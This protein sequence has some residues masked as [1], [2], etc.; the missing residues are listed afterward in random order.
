MSLGVGG[1]VFVTWLLICIYLRRTDFPPVSCHLHHVHDINVVVAIE[2]VAFIIT[3][4]SKL[5]APS[6]KESSKNNFGVLW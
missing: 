2:V 4:L 3:P 1:D 5:A 6:T